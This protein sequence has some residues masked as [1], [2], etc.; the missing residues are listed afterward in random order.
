MLCPKGT[1]VKVDVGPC[2][3]GRVCMLLVAPSNHRPR[4]PGWTDTSIWCPVLGQPGPVPAECPA[5]AAGG[6]TSHHSHLS[7]QEPGLCYCKFLA[8]PW[9]LTIRWPETLV[10]LASHFE[11][12]KNGM[13]LCIFLVRVCVG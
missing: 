5:H 2:H 6:N 8:S 12:F 11:M 7:V 9:I 1:D 3:R 4:P 13:V 10:I